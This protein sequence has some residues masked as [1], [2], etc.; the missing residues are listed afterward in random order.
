[1]LVFAEGVPERLAKIEQAKTLTEMQR[2]FIEM[3]ENAVP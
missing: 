2:V 1:L 3:D